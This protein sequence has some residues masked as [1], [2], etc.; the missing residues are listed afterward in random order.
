MASDPTLEQALEGHKGR[1]N[2]LQFGPNS[3]QLASGGED[4]VVFLW[5][6]RPGARAFRYVGHKVR[7]RPGRGGRGHSRLGPGKGSKRAFEAERGATAVLHIA[8]CLP[9]ARLSLRRAR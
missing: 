5:D 2:G 4:G 3:M 9:C 8:R 7:L 6:F 1:V